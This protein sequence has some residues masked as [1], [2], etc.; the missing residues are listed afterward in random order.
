[1]SNKQQKKRKKPSEIF[2]LD[3]IVAGLRS[4][5]SF[6]EKIQEHITALRDVNLEHVL[7]EKVKLTEED[8]LTLA[9]MKI[10]HHGIIVLREALQ[11]VP[12][13]LTRCT[14]G[15]SMRFSYVLKIFNALALNRNGINSTQ[16][17]ALSKEDDVR[18]MCVFLE[19]YC[20]EFL[21]M[22]AS[23]TATNTN[24]WDLS[25]R[26]QINFNKF[27]TPPISNCLRCHKQLSMHNDPSKAT[28]FTS[29][30]PIPCSKISLECRDC[31]IKYGVANYSEERGTHFYP[32]E[33]EVDEIEVSNVTYIDR[34]LYRWIPSLR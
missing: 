3:N 12:A 16:S 25:K 24:V 26:E 32:E 11:H 13:N 22:K 5:V 23:T 1:M 14:K 28:L 18:L 19:S 31:S 4:N 6:V 27:L 20:P 7:A 17:T 33:L 9:A 29:E 15:S 10:G 30:G 34:K 8:A 21:S 2:D